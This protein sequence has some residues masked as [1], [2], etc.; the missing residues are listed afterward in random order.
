MNFPMNMPDRMIQ[1][2]V[3]ASVMVRMGLSLV[4]SVS[5]PLFTPVS[6]VQR[7]RVPSAFARCGVSPNNWAKQSVPN[8]ILFVDPAVV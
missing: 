8:V 5:V 3:A 1:R 4:A 7:Y 2:A 6:T